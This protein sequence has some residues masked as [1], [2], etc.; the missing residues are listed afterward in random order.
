MA[1]ECL[2]Q[3]EQ[4]PCGFNHKLVEALCMRNGRIRELLSTG[5]DDCS[6]LESEFP[7]EVDQDIVDINEWNTNL[8]AIDV[9]VGTATSCKIEQTPP[10]AP[11]NLFEMEVGKT[12]NNNER[13]A[14]LSPHRFWRRKDDAPQ[15]CHTKP[16]PSCPSLSECSVVG[17]SSTQVTQATSNAPLKV[18]INNQH[19]WLLFWVPGRKNV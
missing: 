18:R 9:N 12:S 14:P 5:P 4:R 7:T 19:P 2:E 10:L 13:C 17:T 16:H 1:D 6:W 11:L 8:D 15:L 3:K